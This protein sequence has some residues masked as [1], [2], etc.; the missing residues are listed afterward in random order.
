MNP[1][2]TLYYGLSNY[3]EKEERLWMKNGDVEKENPFLR[4][5]EPWLAK[6]DLAVQIYDRGI[7][8]MHASSPLTGY[9]WDVTQQSRVCE[10]FRI[11]LR[12]ILG[13]GHCL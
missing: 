13:G 11:D 7:F 5:Y 2:W 6:G 10:E 12:F 4:Q 3:G 9:G 8:Q 1:Y